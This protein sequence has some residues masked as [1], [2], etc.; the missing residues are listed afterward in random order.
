[1][2]DGHVSGRGRGSAAELQ[3]L[4]A[5]VGGLWDSSVFAGCCGHVV[6]SSE[7][8]NSVLRGSAYPQP[9][10]LHTVNKESYEG[11]TTVDAQNPALPIVRNIP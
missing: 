8:R 4:G 11:L 7:L 10:E 1:M 5:R 6:Q 2:V 9:R 3:D